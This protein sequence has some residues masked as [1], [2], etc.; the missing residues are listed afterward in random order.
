MKKE[1]L[2]GDAVSSEA[3]VKDFFDMVAPSNIKF[4]PDHFVCGDSYCN[5]LME[6]CQ[7][8]SRVNI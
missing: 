6:V 8:V 4:Y 5:S 7:E 2:P 1:M 3:Y